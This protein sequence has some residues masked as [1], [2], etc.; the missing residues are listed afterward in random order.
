MVYNFIRFS[1]KFFQGCLYIKNNFNSNFNSLK[2]SFYSYWYPIHLP[3]Y[4]PDIIYQQTDPTEKKNEQDTYPKQ[5]SSSSYPPQ[6]WNDSAMNS[7]FDNSDDSFLF[8]HQ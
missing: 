3:L 2:E 5:L 1:G 7:N 8:F 6:G 4:S